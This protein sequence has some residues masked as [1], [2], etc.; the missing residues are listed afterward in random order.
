MAKAP[1]DQARVSYISG[2]LAVSD[3]DSQIWQAG[4]PV[5]ITQYWSGA[6]APDS[7]TFKARLLWSDTSLYVRFDAAQNEP[8]VVS[9]RPD[10]SK[11][12]IGLWDRDVLEIFIAPDAG[13]PSSY[14]EF[15]VAPT[16]EWIDLAIDLTSGKREADWKYASG[17][18]TGVRIEKGGVVAAIK[19]PWKALGRSPGNG[20]IWRGNLYRCV[21]K[22]PDRGYLA[23]RPTLT[24]EPS[25]HVPARFG[26]FVFDK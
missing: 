16:G 13:T 4:D 6:A 8:L 2:D 14:F 18:E 11:K 21:G 19:V 23:W 17:M 9:D 22:G 12:T 15:E 20:D 10:L 1:N 25:F 3:L 7:R 5:K 24:D 26:K